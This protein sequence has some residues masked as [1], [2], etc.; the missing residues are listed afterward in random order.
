MKLDAKIAVLHSAG[1]YHAFYTFH[2]IATHQGGVVEVT[3]LRS[4]FLSQDVA[5]ISML[6]LDFACAGES[7]TLFGGG[8]SF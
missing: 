5:V 4:L 2:V 3:L 7:E 1:K 6:S 8:L